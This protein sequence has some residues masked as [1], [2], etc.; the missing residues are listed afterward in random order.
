MMAGQHA[1][2]TEGTPVLNRNSRIGLT[3][4]VMLLLPVSAM[5]QWDHL[6]D[7]T[8][9]AL[10]GP[11]LSVRAGDA[12]LRISAVTNEIVRVRLAPDG[13][14]G[15]D[16]S[17]AV[18]DLSANGTLRITDENDDHIKA[19]TGAI[20]VTVHRRPCRLE[21]RETNGHPL[22]I[23]DPARG[24]AWEK[25][26][27]SKAGDARAVRVW[28]T[29][30]DGV[31]VF[32]LGEKTGQLNKFGRVWSMWNT[33]AFGYGPSRDPI[34]KSI[35]FF[36]AARGGR[37]H[38]VF[39]D[40]PWRSSFD[41]A[42]TERE[43]FAYGA[44]GGELNY[45]VIA[46][47]DPSEVVERYTDLTGRTPLPPKW[48]MGYHQCRYSYFPESRVRELAKTFRD[49]RIP[50]DVIYF[51]IHYMDAYRCFTWNPRWFPDPKGLMED[52]NEQG[53]RTVAIID[54][55][56]KHESGYDVY[57]EGSKADAWVKKPNGEVY[58]GRVWPGKAVFP[59]F[60][61][62]SVRDWWANLYPPFISS[63]GIDGIW[64]DMNEPA[65]F[66]GPNHSVPLDLRHDNEGQEASHRAC[67]NVYGM[68]MVR[69]TLEG[70][71]RAN[72]GKRPF[73][74]TRATY[75]GGQ[76]YGATWTGD[77]TSTWEHLRMSLPMVLNLGVSGM[78][79]VGPDIG[80]FSP[81]ATPELYARWVQVGSLFPFARTHTA[82]GNPDQEPWSY[83]PEV[84]AI[85]RTA[86]ERRYLLMPYLYTLM[87]EASRTGM[88]LM[89]PMWLEFP[90]I[91]WSENVFMLGSEIQVVPI[92]FPEKRDFTHWLPPGVWF[93]MH[94][95][96]MHREGVPVQIDASL[97]NLPMFVRGGAIIP[98]QSLVQSLA[99]EA[100]E[101]LIL[102]V[103]PYGSS[104]GTLYEDDGESMQYAEGNYRRTSFACNL[105][106]NIVTFDMH[107]PE[108]SY[109]PSKRTPLV[110]LHGLHGPVRSVSVSEES[111][112]SASS[113]SRFDGGIPT[114]PGSFSYDAE[115]R[116]WYVRLFPDLGQSQS[117]KVER[118]QPPEAL[119]SSVD[120]DFNEPARDVIHSSNFVEPVY[121]GDAMRLA[122]HSMGDPHIVLRPVDFDAAKMPYMR[123]RLST[124]KT[125]RVTLTFNTV[126]GS[127]KPQRHSVSFDVIPDG[128]LREYTLDLNS[129]AE[130]RW[131]DRVYSLRISFGDGVT[132][133]ENIDVAW[134]SFEPMP[135]R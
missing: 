13:Q 118:T 125:R 87:E 64:N 107:K 96:Q 74:I 21:I 68:Q 28:Q 20:N 134:L 82:W 33:D 124:E 78:P 12:A 17:W 11:T 102:D 6:G 23:D 94:T 123:M 93:D 99:D 19:T 27:R 106:G 133:T 131:R 76:R 43:I 58:V 44:E 120:F 110:R 86:I 31:S 75:A 111:G 79:L 90:Q 126:K 54:P 57:D 4:V 98:M 61:K 46:G 132:T 127:S 29:L 22:T 129:A 81:G 41:L 101:P 130:G 112:K 91:V 89:R 53:F 59:D 69:A 37:Y 88:P 83:G 8:S 135:G 7:V 35:P 55:G 70:L 39:F 47:P 66:D 50:C 56:I 16:F 49:K 60:T 73:S 32:G 38:G 45:Y 10:K 3:G 5:A 100:E 42:Q 104:S 51:D 121:V 95:G 62:A 1:P 52:L 122:V 25:G 14:F 67:H 117:L 9:Y 116:A 36:I 30:D 80:G 18:L 92:V 48:T 72:P 103:W 105:D 97:E 15:R 63:C 108:G 24:M 85:A 34:Y 77:N 40:N 65:D 71:R 2:V 84:E 114:E 115:A 113:D 128:T 26:G 119:S 109:V